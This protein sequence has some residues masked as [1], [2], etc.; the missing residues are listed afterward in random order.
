MRW[1]VDSRDA[2]IISDWDKGIRVTDGPDRRIRSPVH[3]GDEACEM[4]VLR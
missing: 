4:V 2:G 3:A 1:I